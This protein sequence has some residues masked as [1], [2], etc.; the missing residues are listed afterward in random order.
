MVRSKAELD[1]AIKA[2]GPVVA[3]INTRARRGRTLAGRLPDLLTA[4]GNGQVPRRVIEVDRPARLAEAFDE[5]LALKPDLLVVGGGDGTLSSAVVHLA[6]RDTALGVLAL[7]TTNNL[8][9]SL[10]IP[11][12]A[13]A[14]VRVLARGKVADVDLG[15]AGDRLFAN[16][17]SMGVSTRVADRVPHRLKAAVGR[18]AYPLTALA[19]LPTHRPFKVRATAG[20]VVQEF[21]THQLNIA[22]GAFHAGRPIAADAGIDDRLLVAYR[23]GA[24]SRPRLIASAFGHAV[25]GNRRRL[26]DEEFLTGGE[27]FIET[28]PAQMLDVDGEIVGRTPI[29]VSVVAEAL[30]VMVPT[31][32]VDN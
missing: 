8:A 31:D 16:M 22:N 17:V 18:A 29:Q 12:D 3:V 14:A 7:G 13:H 21:S 6:H 28:W 25:T 26:A 9:R 27:L 32:F 10:S 23:L 24:A 30:R 15:Q 20:D 2:G 4:A 5:A 11:L 1:A 19:A